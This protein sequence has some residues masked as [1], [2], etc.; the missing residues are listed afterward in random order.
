MRHLTQFGDVY[1]FPVPN[2]RHTI[3]YAGRHEQRLACRVNRMVRH[4]KRKAIRARLWSVE[5]DREHHR[6]TGNWRAL[7][8]AER[9]YR[10]LIQK[11][12]T[13]PGGAPC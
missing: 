11:M 7:A 1:Q 9:R 8:R 12:K 6:K 4:L 5:C 13:A 2:D 3:A 10:A